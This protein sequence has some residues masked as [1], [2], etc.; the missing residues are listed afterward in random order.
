MT[1]PTEARQFNSWTGSIVLSR[2]PYMCNICLQN[3][4]R[5]FKNL[6]GTRKLRVCCGSTLKDHITNTSSRREL[7][8][9]TS[10][11]CH[12]CRKVI[13]IF[14]VLFLK[15]NLILT[16]SIPEGET[17]TTE[18]KFPCMCISLGREGPQLSPDAQRDSEL[19]NINKKS[20][21]YS[22]SIIRNTGKLRIL[23]QPVPPVS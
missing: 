10:P 17:V 3:Q 18:R 19:L 16:L 22:N 5:F 13:P 4:N 14:K 6:W 8:W 23:K 21:F 1:K 15:W 9:V 12:H 2:R 20:Q 11:C 7:T